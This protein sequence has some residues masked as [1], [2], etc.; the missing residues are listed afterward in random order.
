MIRILA[1]LVLAVAVTAPALAADRVVRL[2]IDGRPVDRNGGSAVLH[3]GIVYADVID[4]VKSFNGLVT[5]Q[6]PALVVTISGVTATF[7]TG[8]R[9][10]KV[11][12]GSVVMRGAAFLREREMFVP[13]D[14]FVNRLTTAKVRLNRD[15]SQ[16]DILVNLS[17][18]N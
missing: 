13:L 2:T 1:A 6:G 9:T 7:T 18:Q 5:F 4:L 17:V 15:R 3:N 8:S 12:D 14:T 10:A 16:A 11:G